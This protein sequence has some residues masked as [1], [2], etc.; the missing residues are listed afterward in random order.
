MLFI[1]V[2]GIVVFL[3]LILTLVGVLLFSQKKLLPQSEVEI[4]IND[5]KSLKVET[6]QSLLLTLANENVFLPSACGGSGTCG[7]CKC[8]VLAGGGDILPTEL[9]HL[10]KQ[11]RKEQMRLACQVKV[12]ADLSVEIPESILEVR[13]VEGRILSSRNV[14]TF[15]KEI[16]I[17]LPDDYRLNFQSGQYVQIYVPACEVDYAH[18]IEVGAE[19]VEDWKHFGLFGLKMKNKEACFR[20][21]SMANHP[22]EGNIVMLTVRI[23]TPPFDRKSGKMMKVNPGICSSY[24]FSRKVGDRVELSGPYGDFLIKP[25]DREMM[26]IGG[27]AGMA[28]MRSHI[29]DLFKTKASARKVSFWYGGR[30]SK[31]LFYID[32]F[33]AIENDFPNFSFH[34]ALSEPKKEDNWN[35]YVGF[36]HQMVLD[37][38]LKNHKEPEEIEYYLCGPPMMTAAVLN[39]LDNLGVPENM[40]SFDNFGG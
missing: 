12:K 34:V 38:Y 28:P 21:Y 10:S 37:N 26:F 9:P 39:M 6:G 17:K 23:A 32:E 14:A 7:Y 20:A 18:D 15:I 30:S 3:V 16:A 35:G 25:T 33:R 11:E 22:A 19:F 40:I 29:F 36:I 27:G 31:E 24:L 5:K 1:V 8:K 4:K 13:K 2:V